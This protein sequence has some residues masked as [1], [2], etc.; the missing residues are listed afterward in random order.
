MCD[1][2]FGCGV[3]P[4]DCGFAAA[5]HACFFKADLFDRIA[6]K[7]LMVQIHAGDHRAIA[8]EHIDRVQT[9]AQADFQYHHIDLFAYE[10]IDRRQGIEFKISQRYFAA[11][12]FDAL[13]GSGDEVV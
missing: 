6:Q 5:E 1:Q 8:V 10:D 11:R 13:E 4:A 9:S 3:L 12:R 2:R 7:R